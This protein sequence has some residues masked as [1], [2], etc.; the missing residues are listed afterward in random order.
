MSG[1]RNYRLTADIDFSTL[2]AKDQNRTKS[3]GSITY[4]FQGEFDGNGHEIRGLTLSNSDSGL[5]AYVGGMSRIHDVKIVNPNVYFSNTAAVLALN[6]YGVI[7]DCAVIGCNI[8]A[9]IS[10]VMGGIAGRNYGIIRRC[11][12][13]GGRFDSNTTTATGHGGFVGSNETGGLIERCWTSMDVY[14]KSDYAAAL[15]ACATAARSATAL[16]LETSRR[17]ATPAALSEDPSTAEMS[18]KTAMRRAS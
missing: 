3:F 4:N 16:R 5:F 17:A 7:E 2:S 1:S 13:R 15:S 12:V 10:G 9:D 18:M 14:T 6:N 8:S 11:Y